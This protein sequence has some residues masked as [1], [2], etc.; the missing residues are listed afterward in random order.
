MIRLNIQKNPRYNPI[1]VIRVLN[2]SAMRPS[3]TAMP[4]DTK[5]YVPGRHNE[6][7]LFDYYWRTASS[8]SSSTLLN[9]ADLVVPIWHWPLNVAEGSTCSFS[10]Y[11]LPV[12]VESPLN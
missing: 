11:R 3:N 2:E 5:S 7:Y 9:S 10:A 4:M 8:S 6:E 12:T 1:R